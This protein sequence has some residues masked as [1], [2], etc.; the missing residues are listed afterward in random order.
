MAGRARGAQARAIMNNDKYRA[1]NQFTSM[2]QRIGVTRAGI[3]QITSDDFTTME[4]LVN[5]YKADI[6]EFESYIKNN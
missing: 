1:A 3:A 6:D 4:V 5:Q 2:L